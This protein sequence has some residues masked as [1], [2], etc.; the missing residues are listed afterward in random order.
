M[1]I[2]SRGI[3]WSTED[4]LLW[5]ISKQ[6]EQLTNVTAKGCTTTTT[7]TTAPVYR[8]YTALLTQTGTSTTNAVGD[9][10]LLPGT[11]YVIIDNDSGTA[12]FT[13]VGAP[14][15]D[16]GTFFVATGTTPNSWGVNLLGQLR[17]DSGAPTVIVLENTI[18]NIWF[19]YRLPGIYR[20]YS[21]NLFTQDKTTV[22]ISDTVNTKS[23]TSIDPLQMRVLCSI[24]TGGQP[25]FL[26]IFTGTVAPS[27]QDDIIT[28]DGNLQYYVTFEIRVYN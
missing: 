9:L 27:Y 6:L 10:P 11:T 3:G 23:D 15:N 12:D 21:D 16:P 20:C 14:N 25:S 5:Q 28:N 24:D 13:N 26:N 2:P 19:E 22:F 7:T 8:V 1:A 4:N 17:Y 18:G